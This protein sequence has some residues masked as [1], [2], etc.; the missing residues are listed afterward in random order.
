M[1]DLVVLVPDRD[2]EAALRGILARPEAL[3]ARPVE[4]D[5][6]V[7]PM[8]DPGCFHDADNF[9]GPFQ[10]LYAHALVVFDAAWGG[11]PSN[12]PLELEA[13]VKASFARR[14]LVQ[15]AE[16]VVVAPEVEAWIWSDS[17]HL[18]AA[19]GW[20]ASMGELRAWLGER[21]LW[22]PGTPK[23]SD[24]KRAV[25]AVRRQ[26]GLPPSASIFTAI[27]RTVSFQRCTDPAFLRLCELLRNWF[28][29]LAAG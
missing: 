12:D 29:R 23:P 14:S 10:P 13:A 21:D 17:P 11:A 3:R 5:L 2:L 4:Y 15:W 18:S 9:L 19:L 6:F 28:P 7:H 22:P 1:K 27:A 26:V 20:S 16:V 24:P 8:R 25:K